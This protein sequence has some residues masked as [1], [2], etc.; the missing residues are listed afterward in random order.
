[1]KSEPLGL[2]GRILR[3]HSGGLATGAVPVTVEVDL[4]EGRSGAEGVEQTV[5]MLDLGTALP[6]ASPGE[7]AP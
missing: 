1:M 4:T 3:N 2:G 7:L 5:K 6:T